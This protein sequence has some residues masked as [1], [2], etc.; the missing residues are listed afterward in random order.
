[1]LERHRQDDHRGLRDGIDVVEALDVGAGDCGAHLLRRGE[2]AIELSRADQDG[3]T[4]LGKA[5]REAEALISG[6]TE[7]GDRVRVHGAGG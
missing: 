3:P 6:A 2:R 7:N 5:Q 1:V 4:G